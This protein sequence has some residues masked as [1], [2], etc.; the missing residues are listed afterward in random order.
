MED[1]KGASER[2]GRD[3]LKNRYDLLKVGTTGASETEGA[4][5]GLATVAR[6]EDTPKII[7]DPLG[8]A[9]EVCKEL[10][11]YPPSPSSPPS[12]ISSPGDG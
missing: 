11:V 12:L 2:K 4:T 1:C 3:A 10:Q 9:F 5:E 6:V 7:N 8:D